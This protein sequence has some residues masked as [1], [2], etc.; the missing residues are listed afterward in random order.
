[1]LPIYPARELPIPGVTSGMLAERIQPQTKVSVVE[2]ADLVATVKDRLAS[3][4]TPVVVMTIG[5]G[6]IDRL[7]EPMT[8]ALK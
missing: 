5:A 1:L 4:S 8:E 2:K 7:V 6:D 3:A